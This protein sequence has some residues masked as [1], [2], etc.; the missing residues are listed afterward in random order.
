MK[1]K[2]VRCKFMGIRFLSRSDWKLVL[3]G[4]SNVAVR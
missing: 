2:I 1:S 3:K 4:W